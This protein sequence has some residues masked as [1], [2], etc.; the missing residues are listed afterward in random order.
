MVKDLTG[1]ATLHVSV[2]PPFSDEYKVSSAE[3]DYECRIQQLKKGT[4][5]W[6]RDTLI[7]LRRPSLKHVTFYIEDTQSPFKLGSGVRAGNFADWTKDQK[8]EFTQCLKEK[9]VSP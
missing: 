4:L 8:V 6:W 7:H 5:P 1:L 9:L 2:G 3:N